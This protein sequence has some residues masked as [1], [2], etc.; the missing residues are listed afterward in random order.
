MHIIS[1]CQGLLDA[2]SSHASGLVNLRNL[3]QNHL[4]VQAFI[5]SVKK[6]VAPEATLG[7]LSHSQHSQHSQ[8]HSL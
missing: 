3:D 8:G 5:N 7:E 6:E 1:Q 2:N 4:S